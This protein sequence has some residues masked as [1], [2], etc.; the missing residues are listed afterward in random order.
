MSSIFNSLSV[1]YSGLNASQ[2]AIDTTSHNITNAESEGYT[3]QRVVSSAAIPIAS[4][5]GL[6]GNGVKVDNIK[7]VFDN[8]TFDRYNDMSAQKEYSDYE[9]KNL[10]EL[11]TYFPE[12]DGVGIKSELANY[13]D[14]WQTF[15]DNPNNDAVKMSLAKQTESLSQHIASTQNQV[16]DLQNQINEDIVVS[17]NEVNDLAKELAA[18]NVSIE[19]AEAADGYSANDL[20]DRRNVIEQDIS[21]LIG[22]KVNSTKV[23]SDIGLDSSSNTR[24]GNYT[25]N[26]AGFN[27]VDGANFHPIHVSS[28]KNA[29]G[30]YE[31]SYERQDGALLPME[32]K[33]KG[34]KVAAMLDL[35]GGNIKTTSGVPTDGIIQKTIS[36]LDAFSTNLIESTNN[37][38]AQAP[39]KKMQSNVVNM[40]K[41]ETLLHSPLN[42]KEGSFE[43]IVYDIDGNKAATREIKIDDL[44][45]MNGKKGSNSIQG[46]IFEQ[47]DDNGDGNANDDIDDYFKN[48]FNFTPSASGELRFELTLDPLAQ[49][50]GYTFAIKDVLKDESYDSGSNFAGA[51]GLHRF[52][53]GDDAQSI[54]LNSELTDNPTLISAS[55][56]ATNGDSSLALE[57]VQHQ[58]ENYDFEIGEDKFNTTTYGMFDII[59]TEV[60]TATNHAITKAETVSTQFNAAELQYFGTSKVSIDEEM[61]NLIRYQTSYSASAKI[62]TT[63]DQMMQ[64]LL[65]IKQ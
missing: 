65:G 53:D 23:T 39:T 49:S 52:F 1:G 48:G 45:V 25:L 63:I 47:R 58:F 21:R 15:S 35:R 60:G 64:T 16:K 61:A 9:Q 62:I 24:S 54:R 57:M 3:R 13:Y 17:V 56:S 2:V 27:I 34:G 29:N 36:Q 51:F 22:G 14:S 55:T 42:I 12:I 5:P 4:G 28:A 19:V 26:V 18:L 31:I 38:Y 46:Q 8:F 59:A 6:V 50:R 41:D 32:D 43:I 30:F 40:S 33:I 7:R 11:S 10:E 37:L 20:R 44:T